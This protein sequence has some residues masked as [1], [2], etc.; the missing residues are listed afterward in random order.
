ML[1]IANIRKNAEELAERLAIRGLDGKSLIAQVLEM[2][3]KNR[4]K[5]TE[6]ETLQ[7]KGNQLTS[8][9]GEM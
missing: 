1:Q 7:S 8:Q 5:R 9:I 4:A 3:E 6:M 2:D